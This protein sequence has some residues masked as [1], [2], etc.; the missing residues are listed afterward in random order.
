M[1]GPQQDF[2]RFALVFAVTVSHNWL[3]GQ[4]VMRIVK[5]RLREL[6]PDVE[7]RLI[8]SYDGQFLC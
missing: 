1:F 2:I 3:H 8:C 5:T 6:L 7:V 4:N